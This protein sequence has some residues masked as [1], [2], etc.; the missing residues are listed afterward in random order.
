MRTTDKVLFYDSTVQTASANSEAFDVSGCT[1]YSMQSVWDVTTPTSATFIPGVSEV[2]TLTFPDEATAVDGDYVVVEDSA[3]TKWALA[4]S[5][6]GAEVQTLTFLA[7]ASCVERDFLVFYDTAGLAWGIAVNKSGTATAPTAQAWLDIPSARKA[8]VDISGASTAASV[9]ALYETAMN[10]L[11]GFTAKFTTDDSAAD[12]TMLL[13]S[14]NPGPVTDPTPFKGDAGTTAG[15]TPTGTSII[16]EETTAGYLTA[17][18]TGA[19]WT[20]IPASN[21]D[22]VDVTAASTAA[23][24]AAL[25]ETAFNALTGFTAA[26]TSDDTAANGTMTLTQ[27]ECGA[28]TNPVLKD[29]D[30]SGAGTILGVQSTGGTGGVNLGTN[31]VLSTAHGLATGTV[32]QLTTAT[33]LPT[34]L[35]LLTDYYIIKV[36]ANHI[37][38]ATSL[39]FALAGTAVNITGKG[40]GTHTFTP[41]ALSASIKLQASANGTTWE[42]VSSTSQTITADS[43]LIWNVADCYYPFVRQALTLTGGQ[44]TLA[45]RAF[46]KG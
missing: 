38:F 35:S 15:T 37:K 29:A 19:I 4:L 2:Q 26:I 24:I 3:G 10:A 40:T 13:T 42:D 18:P 32:G 23:A 8:Q 9:A 44:L 28:T 33:T 31:A 41:A 22:T 14:D 12:G 39:A 20:A 5:K 16:G 21:K 43:S 34:G 1:G 6:Q 46:A 45:T 30:D 17:E 36:D 25:A 7:K 27:V 11:T